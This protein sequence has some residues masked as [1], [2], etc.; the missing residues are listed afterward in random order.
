MH[1]PFH[2]PRAGR[3]IVLAR[4]SVTEEHL[5][6]KDTVVV[7]TGQT[8]DILLDSRTGGCGGSLP[9]RRTPTKAVD[10]TDDRVG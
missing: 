3:L 7:R 5:V 1:H 9:H 10:W 6:W 8:V 4:D 2:I